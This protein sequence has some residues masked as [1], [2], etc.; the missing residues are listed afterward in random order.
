MVAL[1]PG[2]IELGG[3]SR[4]PGNDSPDQPDTECHAFVAKRWQMLGVE[5]L[6]PVRDPAP[7]LGSRGTGVTVNF[8]PTIQ[9]SGGATTA[10]QIR[11][12]LREQEAQFEAK[13]PPAVSGDGAAGK[14]VVF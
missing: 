14:E 12:V 13:I 4:R 3:G 8:A 11:T 6:Q 2:Y 9:V 10:D 1:L 7:L 5:A